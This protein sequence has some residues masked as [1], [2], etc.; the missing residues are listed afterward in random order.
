ML[1]ASCCQAI[2]GQLCSP[3]VEAFHFRSSLVTL[4]KSI[5]LIHQR[6]HPSSSTLSHQS[7]KMQFPT[8]FLFSVLILRSA[9]APNELS[10]R[11]SCNQPLAVCN[12]SCN[13]CDIN[14][15]A[16]IND[17]NGGLGQC[18]A[19]KFA[20]CF[21]V[22]VCGDAKN[23]CSKNGCAGVDGVCQAGPFSGCFCSE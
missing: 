3:Q 10:T 19:G 5:R 6:Y 7:G 17:P 15:C 1:M 4:L 12:S 2:K 22:S 13:A 8:L 18:T 11:F 16:G 20:G 21:C 9:A 23:S 14:G